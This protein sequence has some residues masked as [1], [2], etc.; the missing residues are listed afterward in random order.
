MT[1]SNEGISCFSIDQCG[2]LEWN[3]LG[4]ILTAHMLEVVSHRV[5]GL[6][7]VQESNYIHSISGVPFLVALFIPLLSLVFKCCR[8][9]T[10][11]ASMPF[12]VHPVYQCKYNTVV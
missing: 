8:L 6:I 4:D 2:E 12:L 1:W 3:T 10:Y 9:A 7:T 5:A 11:L